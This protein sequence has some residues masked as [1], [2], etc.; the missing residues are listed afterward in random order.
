MKSI[1]Y[2]ILPLL[3]LILIL[4]GSCKNDEPP[5]AEEFVF[6]SK[7]INKILVDEAGVKWFAT[8]KGIISYD[9]QQWTSYTDAQ[10][11]T[12]GNVSDFLLERLSGVKKLWMGTNKGLSAF[13]LGASEIVVINY[14]A[15]KSGIL[16]DNV[17]ALGAD[18]QSAKF[19]GTAK[20]LSI[21]KGDKWTSYYGVKGEE[22]LKDFEISSIAVA[23]NGY[24]YAA[25]QGGGVSRFKFTDAVSGATTYN[26]PW[27]SLPSET[28][29]TVITD[30]NAQWY[31]TD[32]GVAL[33]TS[34]FAKQDWTTYSR[35]D[36][37][38]CDTVYAIAKDPSG[39]VWFGTHKGV[40]KLSGTKWESYTTKNGLIDN[41][42]NTIAVDADQSLWF[43][44]DKGITHYTSDGKWV[45]Y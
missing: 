27:A 30:G 13:E 28:I 40:S 16:D 10:K 19:I 6:P 2:R 43:G 44:T 3:S 42:I 34:E 25:T 7:V 11:L 33:H 4:N 36:G 37:L 15:S 18:N 22:I 8:E 21:L 24:I 12:T 31:G 1:K 14:N 9:G 29:F 20:G 26:H 45:N 32:G 23:K 5:V 41:K 38:V 35:E 17:L 39:N